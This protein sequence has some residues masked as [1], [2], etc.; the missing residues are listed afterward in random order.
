M[1]D[2][3]FEIAFLLS[4]YDFYAL[5]SNYLTG[6]DIQYKQS[7]SWFRADLAAMLFSIWNIYT[8][9]TMAT[10]ALECKKRSN[11]FE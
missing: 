3:I 5:I 8:L 4:I 9:F 6:S 2:V 11:L 1:N 7:V 10:K